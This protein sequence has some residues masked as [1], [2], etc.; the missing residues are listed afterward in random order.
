MSS[1]VH[2]KPE[3]HDRAVGE[4]YDEIENYFI[5]FAEEMRGSSGVAIDLDRG[6]FV[7]VCE[8][9]IYD[10]FRYSQFH[11]IEIPDRA[12][13]AA[14]ACKWIMRFRPV[15]VLSTSISLDQ[16]QRQLA[17]IATELFAM[18]VASAIMNY[19][20]EQMTTPRMFNILM[21]TL[22]YRSQTE[23]AFILLFAHYCGL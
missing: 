18:W 2:G 12:R 22:R 19:D 13:R 1:E 15:F 3:G 8:S 11:E 7:N 5:G 10:L 6:A 21:Y 20:L 4:A 17:L 14:Y 9:Y 16:R 23:D